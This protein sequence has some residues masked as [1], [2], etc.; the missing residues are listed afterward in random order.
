[1]NKRNVRRVVRTVIKVVTSLANFG[2]EKTELSIS[3]KFREAIA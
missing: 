3:E 1:M 2:D